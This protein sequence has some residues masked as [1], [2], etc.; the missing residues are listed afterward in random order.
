[1]RIPHEDVRLIARA[2]NDIPP[3][4]G[5]TSITLAKRLSRSRDR[6]CSTRRAVPTNQE[7][8]D[9]AFKGIQD[10]VPVIVCPNKQVLAIIGELQAGPCPAASGRCVS[11]FVR[12]EVK[13]SKWRLVVIAE[14]VEQH[15]RRGVGRNRDDRGRRV[16]R[17]Q[18]WCR[19]LQLP[20]RV[21]RIKVPER[22]RVVLGAGDEGVTA[23][24]EGQAGDL[25]RV[26]CEIAYVALVM[27]VEKAQGVW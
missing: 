10:K 14:V 27:K 23:R 5:E 16:E 19:K 11:L 22:D 3:I 15:R 1:M 21:P 4:R 17:N 6:S 8:L 24:G 26:A 18:I 13:R 20:L 12:S 25:V 2:S 7:G 9:V